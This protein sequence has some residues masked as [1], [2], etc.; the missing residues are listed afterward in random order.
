[1]S[2]YIF[3]IQ[4]AERLKGARSVTFGEPY[5]S[6]LIRFS[7]AHGLA[8]GGLDMLCLVENP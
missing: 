2:V 8:Q 1:M 3:S 6:P 5:V 4:P 7:F